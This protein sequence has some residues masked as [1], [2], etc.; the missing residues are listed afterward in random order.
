MGT[1]GL[2]KTLFCSAL[3]IVSVGAA[4]GP[5]ADYVLARTVPLGAPDRWDY[6]VADPATR[7]VYVAHG[8]RVTVLDAASG[9]VVGQ[10]A[11]M[12][13]G[14]HG[15]AISRATGQGFTDDGEKGEAVA[16]D[17]RTLEVLRR[18]PAADDADGMVEDPAT[19]RVFV[20]EGD[21]GTITVIDPKAD[22]AV[23]T[24]RTGEKMEYLA[25]DQTG[26]VFV[27]GEAR[28]DV[29]EVDARTASIAARWPTPGCVSP[30][31]LALDD[32][33]HRVFMGCA[34]G[35]MMVVDTRSGVVVARLPI[36]RGSDAIAWDPVRR[37]VFSA[38]GRDGTVSV[39]QQVAPD[40]Y[41]A[42]PT[43]STVVSARNM[44]VEPRSGRL[45]IVGA[46][47][48]P[49]PVPGGRPR[50]RPGTVRVMIY[51]PRT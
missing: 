26:H 17:L 8:D 42:L 14:T 3:M 39:Y 24:I 15:T 32:A 20:V 21:P 46:D 44:A 2:V 37:R 28:G 11:G 19:G 41:R 5:R 16:F 6:V 49:S 9:A 35:T 13:G 31:G 22:E 51:E 48:E 40:R 30:H 29:L 34:N 1:S 7:R 50:I 43:I 45:F 10:V 23:A 27:A 18:I 38:N 4:A 25:A 33:R 47:T 12:P 36:G